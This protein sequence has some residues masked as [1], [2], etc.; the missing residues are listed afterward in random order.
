M[1]MVVAA[2]LLLLLFAASAFPWLLLLRS[3]FGHLLAIP[4]TAGGAL[5]VFLADLSVSHALDVN[6]M[7]SLVVS[8]AIFGLLG[9]LIALRTRGVFRR[10]GAH[11]IALWCAP[12]LGA[13]IW[14]GTALTAQVVPGMSRFG[15]VMNGDALNNLHFA[16]IIVHDNGI[17]LNDSNPV[18]LPAALLATGLGAGTPSSGSASAALTQQLAA[19]TL[20]WV[21]LLAVFCVAAG[22]VCA[23]LIPRTM[24]RTVAVVGALASL[25][26]L[27]WFVAGLTVQWGYFNVD[28]VVPVALGAWLVYLSSERHPVAALICLIGFALLAFAAWTPVAFLVVAMGVVLVVRRFRE[29]RTIQRRYLI[30][31][32]LAGA[33]GLFV[34]F[35][36]IDFSTVFATNGSLSSS[37]AGYTGF[38]NLWWSVPIVAALI[39]AS[40]LLVRNR[41][42]FPVTSGT[43]GILIGGA[44][45]TAL[46]VYLASGGPSELFSGYYPKKFAWILL[47][48]FGIIIVSFLVGAFA[49]RVRASL[50]AT[51]VVLAIFASAI[52]PPGTWPEV[53]QRQ[54]PVRILGDYVRHDGEA[55]VREILTLTTAKHPTILWQSGDPDE[56]I[57]NEWLLLSHGGLAAG[58]SKLIALIAT[59]YFLY[60][61]SGHYSDRGVTGL[62]R[63]LPILD[64]KAVVI[65]ANP[66]V[67]SQLRSSCPETPATV[68]VTTELVGP[69]PTK[70]GENWQ[71]DGIEGPLP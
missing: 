46:L 56:P 11:A 37:G 35:R 28:V 18:P 57:I 10:P 13:V 59:P 33:I 6:Y 14:I 45:T 24:T 55:T 34:M 8:S 3:R 41:T 44:A 67:A 47:V 17:A 38:V 22:V 5:V 31:V 49:G 69:L 2:P 7:A 52:L 15:W 62:C 4:A 39:L 61:A 20:V 19:L 27:T 32:L 68:V 16:S 1:P 64:R 25:L 26:P 40:A 50:L 48:F 60:R 71:G 30:P 70:T 51:I 36:L 58:N 21:I 63:I 66:S 12:L 42:S 23:S 29:F 54:P 9:L 53:V 43:I 65:T